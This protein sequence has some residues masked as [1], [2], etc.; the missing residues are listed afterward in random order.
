MKHERRNVLELFHA[1]LW[2]LLT[3]SVV[4]FFHVSFKYVKQCLVFSDFKHSEKIFIRRK[5]IKKRGIVLVVGNHKH[6]PI[7]LLE[8]SGFCSPREWYF[9]RISSWW[10]FKICQGKIKIGD[11]FDPGVTSKA[12]AVTL[13]WVQWSLHRSSLRSLENTGFTLQFITVAKLYLWSSNKIHCMVHGHC[14]MR[15]CIKGTQS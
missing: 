4:L 15:N 10:T 8:V 3:Y 6:S 14:N 12:V 2:P 7:R 5:G 11:Q 1:A 13:L 9:K